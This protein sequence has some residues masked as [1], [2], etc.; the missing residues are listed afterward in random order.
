MDK[1]VA[2]IKDKNSNL[3]EALIY[4]MDQEK[5]NYVILEKD[6]EVNSNTTHIISIGNFEMNNFY[7]D[8][9]TPIILISNKKIVMDNLE[10]QVKNYIITTLVADDKNYTSVQKEYLFKKG[11]YY[12][13]LQKIGELL[14]NTHNY[15]GMIYDLTEIKSIPDN[16]I[17]NFDSIAET[18]AWLSKM[19]Q[20]LPNDFP[21]KVV[22]FYSDK[23]YNDSLKEINYLTE[24]IMEIKSKKNLI[25]LF[26]CTKDELHLLKENYFFKL[27]LKNISSTYQLYLVDKE[28]LEN[29]DKTLLSKL[30]DGVIIY[31]DCVYKDTYQDE[32]SL[33]YVD[34]NQ[35]TIEQ[36]QEYFKYVKDKYG[37]KLESGSDIDGFLK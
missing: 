35:K 34:C 33:G 27:L 24:K 32:L 6:D 16:W 25:D 21:R 14:Q 4:Y 31:P 13:F 5:I 20:N 7:M 11:I 36:Y 28:K 18:Y 37:Y 30:L 12:I 10:N 15:N 1:Q 22:N 26:I 23:V 29:D 2:I 19:N 9:K 3:L 17:F 8:S